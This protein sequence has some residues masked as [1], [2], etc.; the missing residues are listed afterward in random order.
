MPLYV[1]ALADAVLVP[2][3]A[4]AWNGA[5]LT[6]VDAGVCLAIVAD[7][8]ETPAATV[9]N[10]RAQDRTIRALTAGAP[11]LLPARFGSLMPDLSALR[12]RLASVRAGVLSALALVRNREQMT[13]RLVEP[14]AT[15]AVAFLDPAGA[16]TSPGRRYLEHRAVRQAP[17]PALVQLEAELSSLIR[18]AGRQHRHAARRLTTAYHLIDRGEGDAYRAQ[19]E[20][21]ATAL[22]D[23][24]VLVTGPGPAYAFAAITGLDP[25][26]Q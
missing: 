25:R 9:D 10:L 7:A 5:P 3:G 21:S 24:A 13:L 23:V 17:P 12:T 2:P 11:A 19:V 22:P 16:T 1:Y 4:L 8:A 26:I 6:P 15:D 20:R 14:G 18:Q